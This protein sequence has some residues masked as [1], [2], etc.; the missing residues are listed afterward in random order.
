MGRDKALL[1]L[2]GA[3]LIQHV[4][5]RVLAAAGSATLVGPLDRY[6]DLGYPVMEDRVQ[7]RGPLGGVFTVLSATAADWNLIVACDMPAITVK[8]LEELLHAAEAARAD[9]LVPETT[10]GLEPLCAVYHRRCAAA[11]A[12][13][14][15]RNSL[16]MHDFV[17]SLQAVKWPVANGSNLVNANTPEQW[18]SR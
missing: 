9:C 10:L 3:T 12:R 1:P 16:K 6:Q 8:F 13:A 14:L 18:R 4:A 15:T 11:A 17:S 7:G 5:S 2:E